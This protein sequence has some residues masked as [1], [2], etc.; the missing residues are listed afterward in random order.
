MNCVICRSS[1]VGVGQKKGIYTL[2]QCRVCGVEFWDPLQHPGKEFY[3]TSDLHD[4]KGRRDLQWRH[5]QFLKNPP[6]A[7]GRLL[8]I[9]CGS[10][11]NTL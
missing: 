5:R 10:F 2:Q 9:G 11:P 6:L 3:E 4:I 1:S 7:K 8:D